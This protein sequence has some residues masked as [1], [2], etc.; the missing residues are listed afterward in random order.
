LQGAY[1]A[2]RVASTSCTTWTQHALLK[3][4]TKGTWLVE[5]HA[6]VIATIYERACRDQWANPGQVFVEIPVHL[7]F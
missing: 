5:R 6:D 1:G 7:Q 3:P 4:I 2:T